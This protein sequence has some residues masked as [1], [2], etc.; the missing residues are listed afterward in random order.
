[1]EKST[2]PFQI[3]KGR[4]RA[5]HFVIKRPQ[6]IVRRCRPSQKNEQIRTFNL[7]VTQTGIRF[8]FDFK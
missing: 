8:G 6:K 5:P 3:Q 7:R 1:M 2:H 4:Q